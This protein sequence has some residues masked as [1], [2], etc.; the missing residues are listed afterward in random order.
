MPFVT[1]HRGKCIHKVLDLLRC[2]LCVNQTY[3]WPPRPLMCDV[4]ARCTGACK[5]VPEALALPLKLLQLDV[6]PPGASE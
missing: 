1:F 5:G 3:K 6:Q 4:P 2:S